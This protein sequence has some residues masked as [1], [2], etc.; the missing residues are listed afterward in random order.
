MHEPIYLALVF[1]NHQPIGQFSDLTEHSTNVAYLPLIEML[2]QHP[3]IKVALHY[4]GTLLDWFK[5]HQHSLLERLKILVN[6]GQ[7]ELLSGAYYEPVLAAIP[8]HDKIGQIEKLNLELHTLFGAQPS[9]MWLAERIWEPHLARPIY[10]AGLRYVILDDS[11]FESVG[12]NKDH[13]LFGYYFT[14]EAGFP[15]AVFP[16]LTHLRYAIPAQPVENILDWLRDQTL[17]QRSTHQ[18]PRLALMADNGEKFGTFPGAY[19]HC[20]GD[21]RYIETLF[22][23]LAA[24]KEWLRT[25]TPGEFM[26]RFQSLGRAYLPAASYPEMGVWSL[27]PA[28]SRRVDELRRKYERERRGDMLRHLRGGLWRN[29]LVKYDEINHLHKRTLMISEKIQAMRRG[30]KRDKA[31]ELLWQA[32]GSDPYW[33]GLSGGAYLFNLRVANYTALIEAEEAVNHASDGEEM[34][35]K[36]ERFDF[37]RDGHE[38][39][40][41]SGSPFNAVWLPRYGGGLYELDYRPSAYNLLNVMMRREEGYHDILRRAAYENRLVYPSMYTEYDS[42]GPNQVRAKEP[43]LDQRLHFDWHRRGNCLDHFLQGSTSL[44]EFYRA[45]YAEQ[46]D[47]VNQSYEVVEARC[48]GDR[49]VVTLQRDGTVWVGD[50]QRS[51]SVQKQFVFTLYDNSYQVFYSLY[52]FGK[53]PLELRFGIETV[54]GYDGGHD[55]HYSA[56]RLNEAAERFSLADIRE[57]EGITHYR[58]DSTLHNLTFATRLSKPCFLWQFPLETI[59]LSDGGFERGYQGTVFL[60]VWHIHL[61][62][63]ERWEVQ[64]TQ[65]ASHSASQ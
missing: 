23:S 21:G 42:P 46:G 29:F 52:H 26:A 36:L 47:F 10:Q 59:T 50:T 34:H 2:E 20:W 51:L 37:D 25:I 22:T 5:Q 24:N 54:V 56:L 3:A 7:V 17:Q 1:H 19:E 57:Y 53:V 35:L 39:V 12:F 45:T 4:S 43:N 64:L 16:S 55:S 62:P 44:S 9:G 32:Q 30:R 38:D 60:H 49:A 8:D 65:T 13:D 40:I 63:A 31:L 48:E 28:E 15:L 33:H 6:R 18:P 61:P 58:A 27:L 14:E 11:H 41:L